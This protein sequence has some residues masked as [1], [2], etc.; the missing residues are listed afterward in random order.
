M[1]KIY[2]V[3]RN[4]TTGAWVVASELATGRGGG[5][6]SA[7]VGS[8]VLAI[9]VSVG[10]QS[11]A[12]AA[13]INSDITVSG[14]RGG[15]QPSPWDPQTIRLGYQA[16]SS[17]SL[18]ITE[19]GIVNTPRYGY[20]GFGANSSASVVVD[21]DG[22]TWN[23][24]DLV[25]GIGTSGTGSLS[26]TDQGTVNAGFMSIGSG[27]GSTGIVNVT[28]PGS[29]LNSSDLWVGQPD[30]NG[31][32]NIQ[33]GA[34]V[35]TS[36]AKV[37]LGAGSVGAVTVAG[38]GSTW[39]TTG[40]LQIGSN[41][42]SAGSLAISDGATVTSGTTY[43]GNNEGS[44]GAVKVTGAGSN[45]VTS[46]VNFDVGA[47]GS[48]TLIIE[49]GGSVTS[50]ATAGVGMGRGV[51]NNR[52]A[53][54]SVLVTGAHSSW[55]IQNGLW[56]G[57]NGTGKIT[58]ADQGSVVSGNSH[59]G[60]NPS[61]NGAVL[62]QDAGSTWTNQNLL[63]G[64]Y[65]NASM[66]IAAGGKVTTQD[67]AT[68]ADQSA[69][70]S[71]VTVR[72]E[73]S[74]WQ[75]GTALKVG[76]GGNGSLQ[77]SEGGS[78]TSGTGSIG[79]VSGSTGTVMVSGPG[80]NWT[81]IGT[82]DVGKA[83]N[84]S[85][86][87]TD[88]A[89][90]VSG[91][92][93]V[94]TNGNAVG[95]VTVASAGS[96]WTNSSVLVG[97]AGSGTMT[98]VDGGQV[99][100]HDYA[101][102]G[103]MA[104]ANGNVNVVGDGSTWQVG[105]SIN[106][107][108]EGAGTLNITDGGMVS[109]DFSRIGSEAGSEG[110][111]LVSGQGSAWDSAGLVS[112]GEY[113]KAT[114]T[115]AEQGSIKASSVFL[116][117]SPDSIGTLNVG[118]GGLAGNVDAT[119]IIGGDGAATVNFDHTDSVELAAT[120]TG[121]L[122]VNKFNKGTARL[123][124]ENDYTGTTSVEAGT[125]QAG[126]A[127]A[128][129]GNSNFKV[130]SA[131][132]LDLGGFDQNIASLDNAGAIAFTSNSNPAGRSGPVAGTTLTV[133]GDYVGNGGT[134]LMNTVLGGDNSVT[135]KLV[136]GGSTSGETFVQVKNAGGAGAIT[137]N[138]I[139][140]INVAG[141][142]NGTFALQGRAVAGL[143]DYQ[144]YQGGKA[145]PDDGNWYLRSEAPPV[146]PE[147]PT[148][149]EGPAT[150]ENPGTPETPG[151]PEN[152]ATQEVPGVPENPNKPGKPTLRSEPGAYLGNQNAALRMFEHTMHD[153]VG[154]PGLTARKDSSE[155]Y[156][157]WMRVR[158][159]KLDS[160]KIGGQIDV[161]TNTTVMQLGVEKQFDV[162][163]GRLH[164]GVMGGYGHAT[165]DAKSNITDHKARGT[166]NGKNIG[167]YGTWFENPTGPEG[168]YVDTWL[169]YGDFDN[170]VKGDHLDSEKYKSRT[171]SG[172][173]E[174]GYSFKLHQGESYGVYL[175]PQA[176]VIHTNYRSDDVR[177]D[178]GTLVQ[179]GKAGGTTTRLG[180]R[181]YARSLDNSTNR[182]QPFAEVNWWSGG[183]KSSIAMDGERLGHDLPKNI[184]ETK[185]GAQFEI[186]RGWSGYSSVGYQ[187]GSNSFS[188]V[189]GQ[190]GVK[191]SF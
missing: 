25:V 80:S 15:T 136:V 8:G 4:A 111:A 126:V 164:A 34:M 9:A 167:I 183:N 63:V 172:S 113:G 146:P 97:Q 86:N 39:A 77:I 157:T 42:T 35:S 182:I 12:V 61:S 33:D 114:L 20:I 71:A 104:G 101:N 109:S 73:G 191:F 53:E 54:G 124:G 105:S 166:V 156:A 163:T 135:D 95:N 162:G 46:G 90:V 22:S 141:A 84:G 58:I 26:I 74:Q 133:A 177:E 189:S 143:Y 60:N 49:N 128:L 65:G 64:F 125:L 3:V 115:V 14:A 179:S 68:V 144:L 30:G 184:L 87:I 158:T 159:G 83:A 152:P 176:Q 132:T 153:R 38:A 7:V 32:L 67:Y 100:T 149:P 190:V 122:T 171:W 131:A 142:S 151:T 169:Q 98:I 36:T 168:A 148:P 28:G 110:T 139:E 62:I 17:A 47:N 76:N 5:K 89:A 178:N 70:T 23:T 31:T 145:T 160:G 129:S 127:G 161:D 82:L 165:T 81:S 85:L 102:V 69:S 94:G 18:T 175:E 123:L 10:L 117:A 154:E 43:I 96:S 187:Q 56:V 116:A 150:P 29:T 78:V 106:V 24:G 52:T 119:Y 66:D 40:E 19:G 147:N 44:I 138:G 72:G 16:E 75:V 55:Q 121:D 48:G 108:H 21:G 2:R 79:N 112:I 50:N 99:I 180:A 59:I 120:M 174:A 37:G 137:D 103:D 118:N 181:V 92:S 11:T 41:A 6:T 13:D 188:D 91:A 88:Q 130:A 51:G 134:L 107:G 173:L 140:L 155:G 1:N 45:W 57:I 185:V 93:S 186:G 27:R 170:T